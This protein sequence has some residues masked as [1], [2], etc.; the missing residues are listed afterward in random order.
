MTADPRD[1]LARRTRPATLVRPAGDGRLECLACGHRCQL[2]PGEAGRCEVRFREG[3]VLLAP[4]G[5]VS[6]ATLDPIEKKPFFHAWPG[7]RTL[8]FGMLGCDFKCAFCQN[9]YVSQTLRDPA[10]GAPHDRVTPEELVAGA[11]AEGAQVVVAS[12]NE[13]LITAEWVAAIFEEARARGL[14]TG[15]VSNGHGTPEALE[16]LVPFTDVYKLDLKAMRESTYRAHGGTLAPVLDTLGRLARSPLWLE[17]VTVVVPGQNDS[18]DELRDMARE[19]A[20]HRKDIPWHLHGFRPDYKMTAVAPTPRD[21]LVRARE[22]AQDE[23]LEYVYVGLV[24]GCTEGDED[25]RCAGCGKRL[26][27]RRGFQV[28]EVALTAEGECPDCGRAV[29]GRFG[30]R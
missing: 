20:G 21:T 9:W 24:T 25:T 12:F 6:A 5:Y 23:G 4:W 3:E 1:T 30:E 22:I 7:A 26:V 16:L 13:P 19:L 29:P 11:V 28:L 14:R 17:V 15:I 8:T 2:A 10:A 18:E 27:A